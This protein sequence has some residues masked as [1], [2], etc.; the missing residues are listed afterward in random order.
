MKDTILLSESFESIRNSEGDVLGY[1]GTYCTI[2]R[3]T[4][5]IYDITYSYSKKIAS[6][7]RIK[8]FTWNEVLQF[9]AELNAE[10]LSA[11]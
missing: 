7:N 3:A 2:N 6:E 5:S 9:I 8:F 4:N 10:Q 11:I 1:L